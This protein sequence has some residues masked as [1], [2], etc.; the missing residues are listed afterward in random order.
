MSRQLFSSVAWTA[1]N[2]GNKTKLNKEYML[3]S[4]PD[5]VKLSYDDI[6]KL[7]GVENLILSNAAGGVN[8]STSGKQLLS[9]VE[10]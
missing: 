9:S 2:T 10:R 1:V 7:L 6:L 4:Y 8:N 3:S 5:S